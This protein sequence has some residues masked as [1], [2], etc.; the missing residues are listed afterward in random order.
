M[1]ILQTM[2]IRTTGV[3]IL[4]TVSYCLYLN[5]SALDSNAHLIPGQE[6]ESAKFTFGN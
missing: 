2:K 6:K 3:V 1:K 5:L 4:T